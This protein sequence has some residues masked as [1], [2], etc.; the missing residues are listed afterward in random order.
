MSLACAVLGANALELREFLSAIQKENNRKTD[1]PHVSSSWR[2][3]FLLAAAEVS[4]FSLLEVFSWPAHWV[5][6]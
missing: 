1:A 3:G 6:R 5:E 2:E 4:S